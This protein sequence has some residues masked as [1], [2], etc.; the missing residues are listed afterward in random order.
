MAVL[1]C[2]TCAPGMKALPFF[3]N[4][5]GLLLLNVLVKPLWI[6]G[7]DRQV[8]NIVGHEVYGTYF[9]LLNLSLVFAFL[10][11]AGIS[12]MTNRQLASGAAFNVRQLLRLKLALAAL[13]MILVLATAW[14]TRVQQWDLLLPVL[15]IQVLLSFFTF[16][17]SLITA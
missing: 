7:V 16:F 10:T 6:F 13:Y 15:G 8:Q 9:S 5:A 3:K 14:F 12:N 4:L 2:R 1:F 17:R 11:D